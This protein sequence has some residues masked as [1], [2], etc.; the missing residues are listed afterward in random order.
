MTRREW[1][2]LC[3]GL[4]GAAS[5]GGPPPALRPATGTV[6]ASGLLARTFRHAESARVIARAYLATAPREAAPDVL[7]AELSATLGLSPARLAAGADGAALA[8]RVRQAVRE[9]F[10][11]GRIV[12]LEGWLLSVTELRICALGQ[13]G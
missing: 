10:A 5:G 13:V 2:S 4:L 6:S 3:V 9:D 8:A 12:R 11:A 1:M 7:L